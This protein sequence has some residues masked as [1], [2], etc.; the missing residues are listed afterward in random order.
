ME[1]MLLKMARQ[2][3]ALDEAS[4]MAMG[5]IHADRQLF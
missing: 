4:L 3:D 5:K 2:L 1:H